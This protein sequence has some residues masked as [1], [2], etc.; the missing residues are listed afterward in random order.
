MP[1]QPGASR[2]EADVDPLACMDVLDG[3]RDIIILARNKPI[4]RE[5]PLRRSRLQKA[6]GCRGYLVG[7]EVRRG[8]D[9][10]DGHLV[11]VFAGCR[12]PTSRVRLSSFHGIGQMTSTPSACP[13]YFATSVEVRRFLGMEVSRS[14]PPGSPH[15]IGNGIWREQTAPPSLFGEVAHGPDIT[16]RARLVF[17]SRGF[18][19]AK[20]RWRRRLRLR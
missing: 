9:G 15:K 1:P 3:G 16:P 4:H 13:Y 7:F 8:E 11:S 12:T 20:A 14:A 2:R 19:A 18:V 6:H 5:R 10:E 17:Q